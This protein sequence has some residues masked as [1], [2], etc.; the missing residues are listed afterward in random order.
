MNVVA[1]SHKPE[2]VSHKQELSAAN[3]CIWLHLSVSWQ[4]IRLRTAGNVDAAKM[5]K[6]QEQDISLAEARE[7][8]RKTDGMKGEWFYREELLYRGWTPRGRL[9][10]AEVEQL[11]APKACRHAALIQAHDIPI[12]EC[13]TNHGAQKE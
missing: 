4:L 9:E 6:L 5:K 13:W 10:E 1:D 8:A 3:K 7:A 12:N 11:V 2:V